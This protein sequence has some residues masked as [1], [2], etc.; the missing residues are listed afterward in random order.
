MTEAPEQNTFIE[1]RL[2]DSK[3]YDALIAVSRIIED[4]WKEYYFSTMKK[5]AQKIIETY[6]QFLQEIAEQLYPIEKPVSIETNKQLQK[7][8]KSLREVMVPSNLNGLYIML[9]TLETL[10]KQGFP[11]KDISEEEM[12][13]L[14]KKSVI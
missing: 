7:F 14:E 3:N 10:E 4:S 6:K 8:T 12:Q 2:E 5:S 9:K 1:K 13:K 11:Q